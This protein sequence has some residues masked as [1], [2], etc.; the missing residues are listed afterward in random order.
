MF[1]Y[2]QP[3]QGVWLCLLP[4]G[5]TLLNSESLTGTGTSISWF[6]P[7]DILTLFPA[8]HFIVFISSLFSNK[9][10]MSNQL[11]IVIV[12]KQENK[13]ALIDVVIHSDINIRK[14]HEKLEKYWR[15]QKEI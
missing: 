4:A 15:L 2:L 12:D 5:A 13:A 3:S 14:E 7:P 11:D 8:L 1:F 9:Q 10:V 6:F